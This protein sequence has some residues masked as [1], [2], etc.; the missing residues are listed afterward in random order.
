[1]DT[2]PSAGAVAK[3][4]ASEIV[5]CLQSQAEF[6]RL[7]RPSYG[8]AGETVLSDVA[9]DGLDAFVASRMPDTPLGLRPSPRSLAV[10]G[11]L[12]YQGPGWVGGTLRNVACWSVNRGYR[13]EIEG[14]G[15]WLIDRYGHVTALSDAGLNP[16]SLAEVVLGPPLILALASR[17]TWCLHGSALLF[18]DRVIA[19]LGETGKGK[20]TLAGH[21]GTEDSP[22]WAPVADDLLPMTLDGTAPIALPHYPQLKLPPDRQPSPGLPERLPLG[23]IYVL[24]EPETTEERVAIAPLSGHEQVL[25]LVRH[26]MAGRL[27]DRVLL[28]RHMAFCAELAARIPIRRLVYPHRRTALAETRRAL[29]LDLRS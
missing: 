24:V 11:N 3:V 5:L 12:I 25:S 4:G 10:D 27:F 29:E 22:P 19:L 23:G 14:A 1:M 8:L 20:S 28:D 18:E 6:S 2:G 7:E 17:G 13:I 21:L 15:R 16:A 9:L 26:T